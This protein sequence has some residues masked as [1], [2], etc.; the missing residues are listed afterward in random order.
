MCQ[1][2]ARSCKRQIACDFIVWGTTLQYNQAHTTRCMSTVSDIRTTR[3]MIAYLAV[4]QV[5]R[6]SDRL[7]CRQALADT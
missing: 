4:E 2:S 7:T 6:L 1:R 3:H 5:H